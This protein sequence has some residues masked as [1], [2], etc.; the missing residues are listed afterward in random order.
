MSKFDLS[1][2]EAFGGINMDQMY[3]LRPVSRKHLMT[4]F[5]YH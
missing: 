4:T 2:L 1:Y 3:S 5:T